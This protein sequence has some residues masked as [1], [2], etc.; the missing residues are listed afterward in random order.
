MILVLLLLLLLLFLLLLLLLSCSQQSEQLEY[1][2][3]VQA[4]AQ[5][6]HEMAAAHSC[7]IAFTVVRGP[8]VSSPRDVL[9]HIAE[10]CKA[11]P[12]SFML[13]GT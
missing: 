11:T 13:H 12:V 10:Y 6:V 9:Q 5:R 4:L 3:N 7:V 1:V 2:G 8:Q